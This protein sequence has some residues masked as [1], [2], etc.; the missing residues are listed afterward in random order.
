MWGRRQVERKELGI[1]NSQPLGSPD[2]G[3]WEPSI[4]LS[5]FGGF[6]FLLED[7]NFLSQCCLIF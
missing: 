2:V 7:A 1:D 3:I 6:V 5:E 4:C